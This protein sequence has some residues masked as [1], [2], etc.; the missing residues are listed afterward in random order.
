MI[1][2]DQGAAL[3]LSFFVTTLNDATYKVDGASFRRLCRVCAAF[4]FAMIA[5]TGINAEGAP[6]RWGETG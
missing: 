6:I 1:Y 4:R 5:D 2:G 3:E